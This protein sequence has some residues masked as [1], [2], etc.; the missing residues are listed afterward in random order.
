MMCQS[1]VHICLDEIRQRYN[2]RRRIVENV[3]Q[4]R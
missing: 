1:I 4:T 3:S 2:Q